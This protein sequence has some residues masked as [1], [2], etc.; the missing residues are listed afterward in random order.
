MYDISGRQVLQQYD[1]SEGTNLD[2]KID[3]ATLESGVYF[4]RVQTSAGQI[5]IPVV[6]NKQ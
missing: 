1:I 5:Q 6:V 4:V 3:V 2:M